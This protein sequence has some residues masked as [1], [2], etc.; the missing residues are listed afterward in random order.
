M[1]LSEATL[2]RLIQQGEGVSLEFKRKINHTRK[3]AKSIIAFANTIGGMLIV[4]VDDN[5]RIYGVDDEKYPADTIR[6]MAAQ[7]CFPAV[8]CTISS[9]K[10]DGKYIIL[11]NVPESTNKPHYL[12]DRS[13]GPG[14]A[15]IRLGSKTIEASP[16]QISVMR[17]SK[18]PG[19]SIDYGDAERLLFDYLRQYGTIRFDKFVL[20]SG[21]SEEETSRR[22]GRLI[23]IGMIRSVF[24]ESKEYFT[25]A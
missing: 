23:L 1:N 20:L 22:L 25:L 18:S 15:F 21:L 4:G 3:I 17:Q 19:V 9:L 10:L 7:D 8:N 11:I 14:P 12:L 5:G 6:K 13:T 16:V 2:S 24:V